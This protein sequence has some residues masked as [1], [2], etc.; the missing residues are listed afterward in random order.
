MSPFTTKSFESD[1]DDKMPRGTRQ[2]NAREQKG[3][4]MSPRTSRFRRSFVTGMR[5]L[6][7][8]EDEEQWAAFKEGGEVS[9]P[10]EELIAEGK[11][12]EALS[13][14]RAHAP[15]G[16]TN[17]QLVPEI[18]E[19]ALPLAIQKKIGDST[20]QDLLYW[21]EEE[22]APYLESEEAQ[23][24]LRRLTSAAARDIAHKALTV[25]DGSMT[26]AHVIRSLQ[27]ARAVARCSGKGQS[28]LEMVLVETLDLFENHGLLRPARV[29]LSC[30]GGEEEEEQ[31]PSGLDIFL[32]RH[33][34]D[35]EAMLLR[36][37][38]TLD[39]EITRHIIPWCLKMKVNAD[40]AMF[41]FLAN[42]DLEENSRWARIL[43]HLTD[44]KT[45]QRATLLLLR[46]ASVPFGE[47]VWEILRE[48]R[49]RD[50]A[51]KDVWDK[52]MRAMGIRQV[53]AKYDP[54][55]C[56]ELTKHLRS[57]QRHICAKAVSSASLAEFEACLE[58]ARF[59]SASFDGSAI[60]SY[61]L[62]MCV[63]G[64]GELPVEEIAQR[65]AVIVQRLPPNEKYSVLQ[66]YIRFC[67]SFCD[68]V[69]DDDDDG[70]EERRAALFGMAACHY[71]RGELDS[72][73][74]YLDLDQ[75]EEKLS[76][77]S[78][79]YYSQRDALNT[80]TGSFLNAS[81]V[82][83]D[84]EVETTGGEDVVVV[85]SSGEWERCA[86]FA[87]RCPESALGE[88]CDVLG[89]SLLVEDVRRACERSNRD[90]TGGGDSGG[91]E[92]GGVF[93]ECPNLLNGKDLVPRL[94]MALDGSRI[95]ASSQSSTMLLLNNDTN[96]KEISSVV[97]VLDANGAL[98]SALRVLIHSIVRRRARP[99]D[100]ES[101]D[102]QS[103]DL[104]FRL[105]S[106]ALQRKE[107]DESLILGYLVSL[108]SMDT[109]TLLFKAESKRLNDIFVYLQQVKAGEALDSKTRR[110]NN[111]NSNEGNGDHHHLDD[112]DNDDDDFL[113]DFDYK[114]FERLSALG[115]RLGR[116]F[117]RRTLREDCDRN[118]SLAKWLSRLTE[119]SVVF[120]SLRFI[121]AQPEYVQTV[122]NALFL[123]LFNSTDYAFT[124]AKGDF[125][126]EFFNDFA[127]V[128]SSSSS[129]NKS[130]EGM[131]VEQ[132]LTRCVVNLLDADSPITAKQLRCDYS[133][134][135]D[136]LFAWSSVCDEKSLV[137]SLD[138]L[139]LTPLSSSSEASSAVRNAWLS[140]SEHRAR[141]RL[142]VDLLI[143][144]APE[145]EVFLRRAQ[146]VG[147]IGRAID[148]E[149]L[150]RNPVKELISTRKPRSRNMLLNRSHAAADDATT[151]TR[152]GD[153][154]VMKLMSV[155]DEKDEEEKDL[156]RGVAMALGMVSSNNHSEEEDI[157]SEF[158]AKYVE[159]LIERFPQSS[160]NGEI[161]P[162]L[163]LIQNRE[164]VQLRLAF[165]C[166]GL[167]DD[168][169]DHHRNYRDGG[170]VIQ[171]D[172]E[173]A[174]GVEDDENRSRQQHRPQKRTW[175]VKDFK[176]DA[177]SDDVKE[178]KRR[179]LEAT[180]DRRDAL[181][182]ALKL[183]K[184]ITK[185]GN[186][187]TTRKD[188]LL[189]Q[190]DMG[191]F[192]TLIKVLETRCIYESFEVSFDEEEIVRIIEQDNDPFNLLRILFERAG[193]FNRP[194][195][196]LLKAG[197]ALVGNDQ[198][199]LQDKLRR[200]VLNW[201]RTPSSSR[202]SKLFVEERERVKMSE[203]D[204]DDANVPELFAPRI[205]E[206][207]SVFEAKLVKII[208]RALRVVGVGEKEFLRKF[209]TA[210]TPVAGITNISRA[211]ALR[212]LEVF[213]K[214]ELTDQERAELW[215][216]ERM[217]ELEEC[218]QVCDRWRQ[219][220]EQIFGDE[221]DK[222]RALEGLL[223]D[224]VPGDKANARCLQFIARLIEDFG[225]NDR[226]DLLRK[227][228]Q[229]LLDAPEESKYMEVLD[230]LLRTPVTTLQEMSHSGGV[231][232]ALIEA[233]VRA[234]ETLKRR[235]GA[236][237]A[238]F[239]VR[240]VRLGF[241]RLARALERC[242][243][244]EVCRAGTEQLMEALES[245]SE[246]Q[247]VYN[248]LKSLH[249]R[250]AGG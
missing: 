244:D 156:L 196:A 210:T 38:E 79:S 224:L 168:H 12:D 9:G 53:A 74:C 131:T 123:T 232:D 167:M 26:R 86:R 69:E 157:A 194:D 201:L 43:H 142:I 248:R 192:S 200:L 87:L 234:V 170:D 164:T 235:A 5:A 206:T 249:M 228:C 202:T 111:A 34:S 173:D 191:R 109:A 229:C 82:L 3:T 129:S 124:K 22:V 88:A 28:R 161:A 96:Q 250:V 132:H 187:A 49:A 139:S 6:G 140:P 184:R 1:D 151:M 16:E 238:A 23:V 36:G 227:T 141:R 134:L 130:M 72:S 198:A 106:S 158:F 199:A 233:F 33:E 84:R 239:R 101:D 220:P 236:V 63:L 147:G 31:N 153:V 76:S 207:T 103:D 223:R 77:T 166:G 165:L 61:A 59:I 83:M 212:C 145:N 133:L 54:E 14:F 89:D 11:I 117:N 40:E 21:V 114:R 50:P 42:P 65:I 247:F 75:C 159:T 25:D 208:V 243:V 15:F 231:W 68:G 176:E 110:R 186:N 64:E 108:C 181:R 241:A 149:L 240:S 119:R 219:T 94:V 237:D 104:I 197:L 182:Y 226:G 169:R 20:L 4:L 204:N 172:G 144:L 10:F 80:S 128:F 78:S 179:G 214:G 174:F 58:D 66:E 185:G 218:K 225:L 215:R 97:K 222:E 121:R 125:M 113:E 95:S 189:P 116:A 122:G 29:L 230:I 55:G 8:E 100:Q 135:Q 32:S 51:G 137:S 47:Y 146:L 48:A 127:F 213:V 138:R 92:M 93:R 73:V 154:T 90:A 177:S 126:K 150:L 98:Q 13:I 81:S 107:L 24:C 41:A 39:E 112:D 60:A 211:R 178:V 35:V 85:T 221:V 19:R 143:E 30:E 245:I 18:L 57:L 99:N 190:V 70:G 217:A 91:E 62:N 17:V 188:S 102:K 136:S 118:E 7:V 148:F 56:F 120:D 37:A 193:G 155:M 46:K 45:R 27:L 52:E 2:T 180:K 163:D 105:A 152:G 71:L 209:A 183:Y 171:D 203:D 67:L 115:K 175:A 160:F 242:P 162:L 44:A 195:D 205:S 216:R 246:A